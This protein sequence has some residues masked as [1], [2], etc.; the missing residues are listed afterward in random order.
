MFKK[1]QKKKI[2]QHNI[3]INITTIKHKTFKN[4]LQNTSIIYI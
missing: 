3:M 4:A 1:K 2:G